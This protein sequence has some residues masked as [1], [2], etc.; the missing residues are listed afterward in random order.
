MTIQA[1]IHYLDG[2]VTTIE[3]PNN[4]DIISREYG[5]DY[6]QVEGQYL[7]DG[8]QK[9][10]GEYVKKVSFRSSFYYLTRRTWEQIIQ[11]NPND[12]RQEMVIRAE[13]DFS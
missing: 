9:I 5:T 8:L 1:T 10:V 4:S 2:S 3:M 11:D 12:R 13:M 6:L 7:F